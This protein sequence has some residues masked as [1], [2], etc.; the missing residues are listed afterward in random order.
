MCSDFSCYH[1][2]IVRR[3]RVVKYVVHKKH[4]SEYNAT[5]L[6]ERYIEVDLHEYQIHFQ[7]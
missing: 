3:I 2:W 1:V 6:V 7:R 5:D 4:H